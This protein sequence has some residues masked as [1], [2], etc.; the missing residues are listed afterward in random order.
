M[1]FI[2][3]NSGVILIDTLGD[4]GS[5]KLAQAEIA[6]ITPKP[7]TT[8]VL[9]HA[10]PDHVG[11]L[12]SYPAVTAIFEH[13]NTRA[14]IA[15]SASAS[16]G[17][18]DRIK[19][20]HLLA[21][22]YRPT[23]TIGL[24]RTLTIDGVRMQFLNVAPGHSSGDLIIYLPNQKVAFSGDIV[25]TNKGK[26][27]IIHLG[28]SSLGWI[29]AMKEMLALRAKVYVPGHDAIETKAQLQIRLH[30]AELRRAEIAAMVAQNK[31]L[32]EVI[33]TLPDTTVFATFPSFNETTYIELTKGY[34]EAVPPWVNFV[35]KPQ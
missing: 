24:S 33:A 5:A 9:T 21:T 35:V 30:D 6:K 2:I 22:K 17:S 4:E 7:V 28:G 23:E 15:M 32:E 1:G 27:P 8:A 16:N 19:K 29:K 13:E 14:T 3:G 18:P 31:S 26:Y 25:L 11:G 20:Y 34:P 10:D 12:S